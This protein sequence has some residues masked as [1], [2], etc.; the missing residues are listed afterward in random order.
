MENNAIDLLCR[1]PRAAGLQQLCDLSYQILGNPVFISD[2]AHTILAYTKAV[3]VPDQ[4]W[5]E[6][7]VE[8]RLERATLKQER[9]VGAV[10]DESAEEH[11]PVLVND[12]YLP[13]PRM[14]KTLVH[15][16]RPVGVFVATA[17]L[18]PFRE[19]DGDLMELIAAFV[20]PR[21]MEDRYY[22][23][24]DKRNIE[25][26]LIQL[27]DG[28]RQSR[29]QVA[30][31]L[32]ILGFRPRR[33]T[34]V[35]VICAGHEP[36]PPD[37]GLGPLMESFRQ[38]GCHLVLY[39]TTLVCLWSGDEDVSVW[40]DQCPA[41]AEVLRRENLLAGVSRPL[42][43]ME[44]LR[45]HYLQARSALEIGIRLGRPERFFLYDSLSSF[46]LFQS[47]PRDQLFLYCHQKI[48]E[49]G[50]YDAAHG[51]EL[52]I[53]LQVYLEQAKSLARTAEI[54]FIH[55]NTVRYRIRKCME[56]MHSDLE[57]G[58]EIFSYILSLRI[59]EF[60]KKFPDGGAGTHL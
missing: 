43:N 37:M 36:S 18:T 24:E 10:H 32:E 57:D 19:E 55:R 2:L 29:D 30:K 23:S 47:L 9:E 45:D 6:N 42:R 28:A 21:M 44:E 49:L 11:R 33:Y 39:N 15:K 27:L 1:L 35:L 17:Y 31:H 14:I 13:Y 8:S 52:C 54:L 25:N 26:Y 53:T 12:D 56:L 40:E 59:L 48:R 4:T 60:R 46:A 5:Q 16:G 20:L 3:D 58:N 41:L 7:I 50:E 22:L 51:A 38:L 34:Y